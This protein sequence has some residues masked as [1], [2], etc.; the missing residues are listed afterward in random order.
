M[1][2]SQLNTSLVNED[3]KLLEKSFSNAL[4]FLPKV[5]LEASPLYL[6]E[7]RSARQEKN[8]DL[9]FDEIF[10]GLQVLSAVAQVNKSIESKNTDELYSS[11]T[12]EDVHI[13]GVAADCVKDYLEELRL[14][15]NGTYLSHG[16]IQQA[17]NTVNK[18]IFSEAKR[19]LFTFFFFLKYNAN[20]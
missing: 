7:L 18:R 12:A 15:K 14:R 16:D 6:Q 1:F 8:A 10:G 20:I 17:I 9:E 11:L 5:F 19:M 4:M 3:V 2:V 13:V